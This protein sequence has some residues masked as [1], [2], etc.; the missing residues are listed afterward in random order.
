MRALRM[1]CQQVGIGRIEAKTATC[2]TLTDGLP[3]R[4]HIDLPSVVPFRLMAIRPLQ[5]H[6]LD[7]ECPRPLH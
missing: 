5:R 7:P 2:A 1:A 6:Q 3:E 4:L